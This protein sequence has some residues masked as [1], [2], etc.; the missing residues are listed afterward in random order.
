MRLFRP[1]AVVALSWLT[2]AFSLDR[3]GLWH[4]VEGVGDVDLLVVAGC[5]VQPDGTPSECLR[6]RTRGAVEAWR[7]HPSARIL[8]TGGIGAGPVSEAEA[9]SRYAVGLGLPAERI[10]LEQ[11]STSTEENAQL[12][13]EALAG[14]PVGRVVVV[15]DSYHVLRARLVFAHYFD[16]VDAVGVCPGP[17]SRLRG[18]VREVFAVAAYLVL[19]RL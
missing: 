17:R 15:T 9:A 5:R 3:F 1:L 4:P 14:E 13:A 7:A 8:F 10:L 2:A 19:G 6:N 11:R 18:A 12:A 16:D